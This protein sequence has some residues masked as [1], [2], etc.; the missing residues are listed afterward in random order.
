MRKKIVTYALILSFSMY[1][2]P[3]ILH[4]DSMSNEAS[5]EE[6][7]DPSNMTSTSPSTSETVESPNETEDD[8][9]P[10]GSPVAPADTTAES[11]KSNR[12]F[13][14]NLIIAGVAVVVAVVSI[15]VVSNN[16]G[17]KQ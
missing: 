3:S 17:K 7:I 6:T 13:W 10:V 8:E 5:S 12:Q 15:L 1:S 2:S 16:N 9:N 4:A 14:T 11:K